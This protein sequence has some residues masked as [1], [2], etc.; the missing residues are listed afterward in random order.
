MTLLSLMLVHLAALVM[1]GVDN[2]VVSQTSAS[3]G[4]RAGFWAGL[5]I[6]LAV[7]LWATLTVAGL[8]YLV[9]L[10]S[11]HL[12]L[13]LLGASY[14]LWLAWQLVKSAHQPKVAV[15]ET[16]SRVA[17]ASR[18]SAYL[19][20]GFLTNLSNPKA[21]IYFGSI[22]TVFLAADSHIEMHIL[23][24]AAII[25]ET[26]V[27]FFL[28]SQLFA[29]PRVI[30]AYHRQQAIVEYVSAALFATFAGYMLWTQFA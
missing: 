27:W 15:S 28:W 8:S 17:S 25:I 26:F 20:K 18:W 13:T 19:L 23:M 1:P 5:G 30:A 29:I 6:T 16:S 4:R 11:V 14:L 9:T 24:V 3:H 22:F 21:V 2:F 7:L 10:P 12:V